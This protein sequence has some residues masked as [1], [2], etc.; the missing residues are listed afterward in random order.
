M[1]FAPGFQSHDVPNKDAAKNIDQFTDLDEAH[2]SARRRL[3]NNIYSM[4]SILES[5]PYINVCTDIF[6]EKLSS[7]VDR[8]EELDLGMWLQ[9]SVPLSFYC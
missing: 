3:L 6:V 2:H 7:F 8:G 4:S 5:E 1:R 9:M